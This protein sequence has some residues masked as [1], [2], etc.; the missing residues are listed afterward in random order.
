MKTEQDIKT[1]V[2]LHIQSTELASAVSGIVTTK[3]RPKGSKKEDIT[4]QVLTST[5]YQEQEAVIN[6]NIWI[7]MKLEGGQY[8]EN[9]DREQELEHIASRCL[10]TGGI[11]KDY[12]F[13]LESQHTFEVESLHERC[14]NNKL[15]YNYYNED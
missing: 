14:I 11:G 6:V 3:K 5:A 13:K 8:V 10:E 2:A 12:R 4:I 1:D 7:P 15:L 9:D